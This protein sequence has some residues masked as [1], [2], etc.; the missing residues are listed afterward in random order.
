MDNYL[1]LVS[2]YTEWEPVTQ[3]MKNRLTEVDGP[4]ENYKF[5]YK[6]EDAITNENVIAMRFMPEECWLIIEVKYGVLNINLGSYCLNLPQPLSSSS[7]MLS[8][9]GIFTFLKNTT[10]ILIW[11]DGILEFEYEYVD[12]SVSN[13]CPFRTEATGIHFISSDMATTEYRYT[14]ICK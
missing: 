11:F 8:S 1:N 4:Y 5:Q 12:N 6:T 2:A 3:A 10:H 7:N 14:N 13:T 9:G